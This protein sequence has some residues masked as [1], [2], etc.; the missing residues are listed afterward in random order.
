[1]IIIIK[2]PCMPSVPDGSKDP[3]A[4]DWIKSYI[5]ESMG[6]PGNVFLGTF[7]RLDRPA[8]GILAFSR[9]SKSAK[10]MTDKM[11]AGR[12]KK[13]YLALTEGRPKKNQGKA[14]LWLCKDKKRNMVHLCR[15]DQGLK[16][17]SEW[18][19]LM[20]NNGNCLV[21]VHPLT[22]RPHQVRVTL[23]ALRAPIMGDIKYGAKHPLKDRSI[24]LH[25]AMLSFNHPTQKKEMAFLDLP[26]RYPFPEPKEL[27]PFFEGHEESKD[28]G[29]H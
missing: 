23:S 25:A 29:Y 8:S 17:I 19:V 15:A 6:K 22:G 24:A 4:Y 11:K 26:D 5:K 28:A 9:T 21:L 2:P 12:I 16:A 1:M 3:S 10:R 7:Q 20:C 18:K 13:A 27:F 14:T